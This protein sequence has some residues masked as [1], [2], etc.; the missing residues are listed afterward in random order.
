M[1][2][3]GFLSFHL[4]VPLPQ[5][6]YPCTIKAMDVDLAIPPTSRASSSGIVVLDN[7]S[8]Q[9]RNTSDTASGAKNP[10]II[11]NVRHI[12]VSTCADYRAS[13]MPPRKYVNYASKIV[14]TRQAERK[15]VLRITKCEVGYF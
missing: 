8:I 13:S 5:G 12:F 14:I 7:I 11:L 10:G 1:G 4:K 2:S 3:K 9:V 15:C 6:E